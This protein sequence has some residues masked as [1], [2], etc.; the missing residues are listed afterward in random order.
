MPD[1]RVFLKKKNLSIFT[2]T[3]NWI[4]IIVHYNAIYFF[5]VTYCS[6]HKTIFIPLLW[7]C[8]KF[9]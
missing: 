6:C 3:L 7:C 5:E 1:N 9:I 2:S 8:C 4:S